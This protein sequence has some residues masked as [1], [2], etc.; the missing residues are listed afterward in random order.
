MVFK[1]YF[2][3]RT[4]SHT[5]NLKLEIAV[6][7]ESCLENRI[8]TQQQ[9]GMFNKR[10]VSDHSDQLSTYNQCISSNIRLSFASSAFK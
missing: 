9:P 7:F 3:C 8:L 5:V 6:F 4:D 2:L 1:W 10:I